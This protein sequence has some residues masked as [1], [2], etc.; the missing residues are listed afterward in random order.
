MESWKI[1]SEFKERKDAKKNMMADNEK[2]R[3]ES[4][5]RFKNRFL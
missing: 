1:R 5:A 2:F 4:N 3:D